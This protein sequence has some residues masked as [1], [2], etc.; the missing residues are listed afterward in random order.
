MLNL[1]N[2]HRTIRK[3]TEQAIDTQILTQLLEAACRTS[4]TGNMQAYSVVVTTDK[5]IKEQLAPAHFN[6]PMIKQAPVVLTFCADY[7]R[8]SKWC[9]QRQ[10]DPGYDNFQSFMAT[11]IDTLLAAQTFCIAAES[12]GFGICY[13]GTTTYNAGEIIDALKLPR[14]VVPITTITLGYPAETPEQTDRLPLEAVVHYETYHDFTSTDIDELY[15]EKENS[16]F[17]KQFVAE[18]NKETLAQVF[19]DIRYSR[20]NNE[21]FSNKFLEVLKEQG[22]LSASSQQ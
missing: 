7:N 21:F 22:F 4:N 12:V 14:L 8:F 1:L 20:E 19:T 3:Y 18:N 15:A 13:L 2:Q 17:Y 10:A 11:A 6:Q 9:E 16:E 5:R